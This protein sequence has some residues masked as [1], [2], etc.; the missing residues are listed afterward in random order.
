MELQTYAGVLL[1][2]GRSQQDPDGW[3][4]ELDADADA[5]SMEMDADAGGKVWQ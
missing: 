5:S 3:A 2:P 1:M 4:A